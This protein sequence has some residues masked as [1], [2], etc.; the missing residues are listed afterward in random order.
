MNEQVPKKGKIKIEPD[1]YAKALI[2]VLRFASDA[3]HEASWVEVY[4]WLVGKIETEGEEKIVHVYD[5]VPIHHGKDIEVTW[6]AAAYVR[7]AEFD[8]KL[9][10]KSQDPENKDMEGMFI[11]GW[12]HS[13]PKLDFFLSNTDIQNHIGFQGPN[14]Q[15]I[16]IVFDHSKIV[17]YKNLGFKI[18]RLDEANMD[19]KYHEVDFNK[20]DF[21][22]EVLG[23]I[24]LMQGIVEN[25]QRKEIYAPEYGELPSYFTH[26]ILPQ[27]VPDIDRTP[28]IDLNV[29]FEKI[30]N[31]SQSMIE[32]FL[33]DSILSKIAQQI[34]PALEEWFSSFIPY[35]TTSLNKWLLKLSEKLIVTNKLSLGSLYTLGM[36]IENYLKSLA[37]WMK[38]QLNT[39]GKFLYRSLKEHRDEIAKVLGDNTKAVEEIIQAK[40]MNQETKMKEQVSSIDGSIARIDEK[41]EENQGKIT[42][43]EG[44][45]QELAGNINGLKEVTETKIG[46]LNERMAGLEASLKGIEGL[47]EAKINEEMA[48]LESQVQEKLESINGKV[49]DSINSMK[50]SLMGELKAITETLARERESLE[51]LTAAKAIKNMQKDLKNISDNLKP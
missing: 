15:S 30:F 6:D 8:E 7:A 24:Y 43:L 9:F 46:S 25:F 14:P 51:N 38:E 22:R 33:G 34:N 40:L 35:L 26:L 4:G 2:H 41:I 36:G 3:L 18:F 37:K 50:E 48:R 27:S 17:P 32:K 23:V 42:A 16:A 12:Y 20:E 47:I 45:N 1:A 31:G 44:T 19:S 13:H 5:A 10:Q 11:V 28:A 49:D 21:T 29:L 39:N